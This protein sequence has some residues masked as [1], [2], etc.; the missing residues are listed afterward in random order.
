MEVS[1]SGYYAWFKRRPSDRDRAN[2]VLD[3]QINRIYEQHK[4]RYGSP[5]IHPELKDDGMD[6]SKAKVARRMKALGL[7]AVQAKGLCQINSIAQHEMLR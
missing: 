3:Q 7:K 5:R 4:G 6:C 2:Q 1:R